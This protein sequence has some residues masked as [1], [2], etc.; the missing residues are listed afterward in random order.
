[1][2]YLPWI[3]IGLMV[4]FLFFHRTQDLARIA[5]LEA[6]AAIVDTVYVRDTL[7]LTKV[8]YK[9][10]SILITQTDTV[11]H[12][13]TVIRWLAAERKAC[14]DVIGTCERRVAVRDSLIKELKKKPSVWSKLPWLVGG[15][16]IHEVTD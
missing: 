12:R 3:L 13:D 9:T 4:T 15:Y 7:T 16:L 8:R 11:V 2:K 1:M 5:E 6:Q 10:D 14:D